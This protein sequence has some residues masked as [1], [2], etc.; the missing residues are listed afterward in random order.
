MKFMF[1]LI[2][3]FALMVSGCIG[4]IGENVPV[5]YVNVTVGEPNGTMVIQEIE[6]HT[7][8]MP[9]L[10]APQERTPNEFPAIYVNV[11]QDMFPRAFQTGKDYSGPGVYNFTL[12]FQRE[13]NRSVPMQIIAQAINKTSDTVDL[14]VMNFNWTTARN[15]TFI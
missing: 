9:K 2:F 12:G 8:E 3:V 7:G 6:A 15:K 5:M 1:I 14:K 13:I 11:V 10:T 4:N